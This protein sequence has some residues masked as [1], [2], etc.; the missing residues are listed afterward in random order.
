[1]SQTA[2]IHLV[3]NNF[4][5]LLLYG[6]HTILV[7]TLPCILLVFFTWKL[8]TAIR[9]ADKKHA[10]LIGRAP[11]KQQQPHRKYSESPE[12][13]PNSMPFINKDVRYSF[14]ESGF[15]FNNNFPKTS[16]APRYSISDT[17]RVHGLRQN[18]RVKFFYLLKNPIIKTQKSTIFQPLN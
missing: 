9:E 2:L 14:D 17:K 13:S 7:H 15:S 8:L 5:H 1:M 12:K 10:I 6:L 3:G 4:Y 16:N 11:T 18:T